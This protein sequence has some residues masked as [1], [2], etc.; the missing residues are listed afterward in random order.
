MEVIEDILSENE[1]LDMSVETL[2]A[3]AKLFNTNMNKYVEDYINH[4]D[5]N[6]DVVRKLVACIG[7]S[8]AMNT[9]HLQVKDKG[10]MSTLMQNNMR[11]LPIL[12]YSNDIDIDEFI[13]QLE[14]LTENED[15]I[16]ATLPART[17]DMYKD[18]LTRISKYQSL[19]DCHHDH[20]LV[21]LLKVYKQTL[22]CPSHEKPVNT[23]MRSLAMNKF[24]WKMQLKAALYLRHCLRNDI[25][26]D[27]AREC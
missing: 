20:D 18:A 23:G 11:D 22:F 15:R 27:I 12:V 7:D 9:F 26:L 21:R 19:K 2:A 24:R 25:S 16:R 4:P 14:W 17:S 6:K 10:V 5:A 13:T 8:V 3:F 1:V